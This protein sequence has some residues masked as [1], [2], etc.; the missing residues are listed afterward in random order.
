M[1]KSFI[2]LASFQIH[3]FKKWNVFNEMKELFCGIESN[4]IMNI[5]QLLI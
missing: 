2:K 3:N 1:F 4:K 5:E